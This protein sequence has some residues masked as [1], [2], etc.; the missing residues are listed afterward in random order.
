[1][2]AYV[3]GV[4][5][6]DTFAVLADATRTGGSVGIVVCAWEPGQEPPPHTMPG[7][8]QVFVM[9]GGGR[10]V[11]TV[12]GRDLDLGAGQ[13]AYVPRGSRVAVRVAGGACRVLVVLVPPGPE[14]YLATVSA[15][16]GT[17]PGTL[18]TLAADHG[19]LVHPR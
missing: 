15:L 7:T 19:V 9:L 1:M 14:A 3:A 16:P 11:L 18:I 8:D 13:A 17:S 5:P 6:E 12:D 2:P 4:D 10:C